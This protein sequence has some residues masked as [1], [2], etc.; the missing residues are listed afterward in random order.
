MTPDVTFVIFGATGSL[1]RTKLLP[2]LARAVIDSGIE[3]HAVIGVGTTL[4]TDQDF[5]QIVRQSLNDAGIERPCAD[6]FLEGTVAY[7]AVGDSGSFATLGD[8]VRSIEAAEG[9]SGNRVLYLAVPPSKLDATVE[10]IAQSGLD[11]SR[12]WTRLVVEKPFGVDLETATAS[13]RMIHKVFSEDDVYRIDH[14]LGKETVRNLLV[15]RFANALFEHMWD[16]GQIESVEI[17]V[18]ESVGA[19]GRAA[20]Y[21]E[22]GAVRDMLQNH[23]TQLLTLIAMEPPVAMTAAAIRSEKVKVLQSA[24]AIAPNDAVIARYDAGTVNGEP[25]SAYADEPGVDPQS[26]TPTFVAARLFID[27]WRWQGVPFYLRTGK[28]M[29]A[30]TTQIIVRF[31]RPPVCLV[32]APDT[33]PG[34]QNILT[35]RL[36]PDERFELLIDVKEPGDTMEI[37]RI[38]LTVRY[39]DILADA[40]DAYQTLLTDVM[41]G[42]QTLFVRSDEVEASWRLYEPILNRT[43][44]ATYAPGTD[45]PAIAGALISTFP[46]A[47]TPLSGPHT[48][49]PD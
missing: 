35:L 49:L 15:F 24:R 8:R 9:L 48:D 46:M 26:T 22:S 18:A 14:Y 42:D 12:G 11:R 37:R 28:M 10:G 19:Q 41:A 36:Q 33:C 21:D 3:H 44:L 29:S 7:Q 30:R 43:D 23:L 5:A 6:H 27:N 17:T 13:N 32:H 1:A 39:D 47:W 16:R 4:R 2:S 34:H 38:P 25:F 31:A 40:P 20:Y 45:G